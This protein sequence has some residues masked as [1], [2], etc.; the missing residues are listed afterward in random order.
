MESNNKKKVVIGVS[1][2]VVLVI[3][4]VIFW[5]TKDARL[6][7]NAN[8]NLKNGNFKEAVY[9]SKKIMKENPADKDTAVSIQVRAYAGW[10]DQI[11]SKGNYEQS[12]DLLENSGLE[13]K[14]DSENAVL[15]RRAFNKTYDLWIEQLIQKGGYTEA[16]RLIESKM[17][18]DP[19]NTDANNKK[20]FDVYLLNLGEL[21]SKKLFTEALEFISYSLDDYEKYDTENKIQKEK[22]SI[23]ELAAVDKGINGKNLLNNIGMSVCDGG[24]I[25]TDLAPFLG[26]SQETENV[27]YFCSDIPGAE[28]M[29]AESLSDLKCSVTMEE[30]FKPLPSCDYTGGYSLVPQRVTWSFKVIDLQ[31]GNISAEKDLTG[32]DKSCP[33]FHT[34]HE[35][36]F[37]GTIRG[38][39]PSETAIRT[40]LSHACQ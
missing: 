3:A 26:K 11:N 4:G 19:D 40:F 15:T 37:R 27:Y 20:I 9:L 25:D 24:Q 23:L 32:S 5:L 34:F 18:T 10:V 38:Y 29:Q 7:A 39:D 13:M 22:I 14:G 33:E 35:G 17:N 16:V 12:I 30:T 28:L 36:D 31:T 1:L 8:F 21:K 6:I 2:L